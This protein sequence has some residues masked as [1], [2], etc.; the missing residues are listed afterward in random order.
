MFRRIFG[1]SAV[2]LF[3]SLGYGEDSTEARLKRLE[4]KVL[5]LEL[6]LEEKTRELDKLRAQ[7][8]NQNS[9][10]P[11]PRFTPPNTGQSLQNMQQ[12]MQELLEQFGID[13]DPNM[14]LFPQPPSGRN[15][16]PRTRPDRTG[17][18]LGV[19]LKETENGVEVADIEPSSSAEMAG[20]K[21]GDIIA[22]FDGEGI[23]S[24][25]ELAK[26]V[27]TREVGQNV[28]VTVLRDGDE[29]E[30]NVV[31]GSHQKPLPQKRGFNFGRFGTRTDKANYQITVT[32]EKENGNM[33]VVMDAPGLFISPELKNKLAINDN[34]LEVIE[35]IFAR[36]RNDFTSSVSEKFENKNITPSINE[37]LNLR[38]LAETTL[39]NELATKLDDDQQMAVQRHLDRASSQ[40]SVSIES[41]HSSFF[42]R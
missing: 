33:S 21:A 25:S 13:I 20:I 10:L 31:L 22:V 36:A 27:K 1:M 16:F 12:D 35:A 40:W 37:L 5:E 18:F 34:R 29:L 7:L 19:H 32:L 17:A 30:L 4:E 28:S 23:E 6:R 3:A 39:M 2:L 42:G 11:R 41:T 9:N 15:M 26:L 38:V 14:G 24:A 8:E